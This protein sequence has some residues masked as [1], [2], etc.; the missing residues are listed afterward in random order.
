VGGVFRERER[1]R[2]R[3]RQTECVSRFLKTGCGRPRVIE[4]LLS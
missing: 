2:A 3:E 4:E 1:E